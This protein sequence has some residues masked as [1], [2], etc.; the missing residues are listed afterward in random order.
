MTSKKK[1]NHARRVREAFFREY[2]PAHAIF[3]VNEALALQAVKLRPPVLDLGCGDGRFSRLV[4]GK[5]GLEV[6]LDPDPKEAA[7]AVQQQAYRKVVVAA[8]HKIPFAD[9]YF[10]TVLSNSVL[11]H[12]A[13][14]EPV[15]AEIYRVLSLGGQLLITVPLKKVWTSQFYSFFI[16]GYARLKN[17][18]WKHHQLLTVAQWQKLLKKNGFTV[19]KVEYVNQVRLARWGD[20][21]F[22]FFWLGPVPRL[23]AFFEEKG[24]FRRSSNGVAACLLAQ[25][26]AFISSQGSRSGREAVSFAKNKESV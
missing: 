15:L 3:R 10:Q 19:E 9:G 11:E 18:V 16:P 20:L 25:K 7:R 6:G 2:P 24:F 13:D 17:W 8:G 1:Q 23:G 12:I 5:R 14:V 22:P 26:K 4:F 21:L